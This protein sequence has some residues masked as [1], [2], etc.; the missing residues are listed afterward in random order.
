MIIIN[1][2]K[3]GLPMMKNY[4][5]NKNEIKYIESLENQLTINFKNKDPINIK[6]KNK[7]KIKCF[8]NRFLI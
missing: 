5:V 3:T 4:I 6:F 2:E 8:I 1:E 7:K